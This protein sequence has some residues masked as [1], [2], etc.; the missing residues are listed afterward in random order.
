LDDARDLEHED[1]SRQP[2]KDGRQRKDWQKT[3]RGYSHARR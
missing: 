3:E 1:R 2:A